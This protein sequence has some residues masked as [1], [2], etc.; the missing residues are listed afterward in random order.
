MRGPADRRTI[1]ELVARYE[2]EPALQDVYVEGPSDRAILNLALARIAEGA[3]PVRAFE[4]DNIDV[5]AELLAS[6]SLPIGSRSRIIALA[7]ELEAASAQDLSGNVVCLADLDLDAILG[8]HPGHGLLVYTSGLS[9]EVIL[10]TRPVL[11]KLLSVVLLATQSAD[12]LLSQMLPIL[13]ERV[14]Q[15][16]ACSELGIAPTHPELTRLCTYDGST[17]RCRMAD[18]VARVLQSAGAADR[19]EEFAIVVEANRPRIATDPPMFVH[20]DDFVELLRFCARQIKPSSVPDARTFRRFLFG[21]VEADA[22]IGL[23]EVQEILRRFVRQ[24]A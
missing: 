12:D 22:I 21:L 7:A 4:V 3:Y 14:L 19:A 18:F 10:A 16:V 5:P 9:L 20:A 8:R 17:L 15:R 24:V 2:L 23:P 1:S 11:S 6:R 13:N